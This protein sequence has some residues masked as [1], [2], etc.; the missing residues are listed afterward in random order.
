MN[1]MT[2]NR[3]SGR[4]RQRSR[5]DSQTVTGITQKALLLLVLLASLG[6]AFIGLRMAGAG[7]ASYQAEAF[8][9]D[10][11]SKGLQPD[12]RAWAVAQGAALR[13][14]SRYPTADGEYLD[15][16]GRVYSWQHISEPFGS[17]LAEPSRQ[18]ALDAYRAAVAARPTWPYTWLRL[19]DTKLHLAQFDDEFRLALARATE[20]GPTRIQIQREI[21]GIAFAAW[22]QL[23]TSERQRALDSAR[24]TVAYGQR[25][26]QQIHTR[27]AQLGLA[28]TLC[29][30]LDEQLKTTRKLC[31]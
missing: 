4:K 15:L 6:L 22:P 21:A 23:D 10:W 18:A 7:I 26:A 24:R 17:P 12:P 2:L 28:D 14:I 27:A 3:P 30:S 1:D 5:S 9:E 31:Q 20:L 11:A 29:A 16:L 8:L 19:A 13:A 25:D